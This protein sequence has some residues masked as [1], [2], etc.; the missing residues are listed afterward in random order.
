MGPGFANPVLD[1]LS[2]FRHWF[3]FSAFFL[4][5]LA[6]AKTVENARS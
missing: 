5:Q 2:G 3:R 1:R 4:E 6:K